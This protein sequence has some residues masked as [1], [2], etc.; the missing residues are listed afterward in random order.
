MSKAFYETLAVHSEHIE[1]SDD[2]NVDQ[3]DSVSGSEHNVL[4]KY[5][6]PSNF[7]IDHVLYALKPLVNERNN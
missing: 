2:Q 4:M 3:E 7:A 5:R 6:R 1:Q